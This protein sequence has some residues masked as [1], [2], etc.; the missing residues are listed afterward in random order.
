MIK[1]GIKAA[2]VEVVFGSCLKAIY[3]VAFVLL[4]VI[5]WSVALLSIGGSLEDIKRLPVWPFLGLALY[6]SVLR[7]GIT[8]F[9]RDTSDDNRQRE[10]IVIVGLIGVVVSS[11]LLTLAI[12]HAHN[13]VEKIHSLFYEFVFLVVGLGVFLVF[14]TKTVLSQRKDY[15]H[16]A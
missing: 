12:M 13:S 8:A 9:H 2:K 1:N 10:L 15:K 7:D 11:V 14:F 16:Y 5:V 6:S 3:E 4:P